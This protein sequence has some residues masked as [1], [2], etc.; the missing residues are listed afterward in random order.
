MRA[1]GKYVVTIVTLAGVL[2][3]LGHFTMLRGAEET[4][5]PEE[6]RVSVLDQTIVGFAATDEPLEEVLRRLQQG[7]PDFGICFERRIGEDPS[8]S[9]RV[10]VTVGPIENATVAQVL[11]AVTAAAEP[12]DFYT[13]YETPIKKGVVH[14][15]PREPKERYACL[16]VIIP[17]FRVEGVLYYEAFLALFDQPELDAITPGY[18]L[19]GNPYEPI[20]LDLVNV[21]VRDA[22]THIALATESGMGGRS[23]GTSKSLRCH[24]SPLV[25]WGASCPEM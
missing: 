21:A 24:G 16:D 22:L 13:W 20:S 1:F 6:T 17:H 8:A 4:A 18:F 7:E 5:P 23:A 3:C 14:I 9:P 19:H 10:S 12:G 11:D 15:L 2:V 25:V